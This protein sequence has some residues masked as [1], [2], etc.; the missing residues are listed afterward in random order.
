MFCLIR[1]IVRKALRVLGAVAVLSAIQTSCS[2]SSPAAASAAPVTVTPDSVAATIMEVLWGKRN[3]MDE[4]LAKERRWNEATEAALDAGRTPTRWVESQ[5]YKKSYERLDKLADSCSRILSSRVT[6]LAWVNGV[7]WL[8]WRDVEP[9]RMFN[10]LV[11]YGYRGRSNDGI[12]ASYADLSKDICDVAAQVAPVYYRAYPRVEYIE[13]VAH[14][15]RGAVLGRLG[16]TRRGAEIVGDSV[17]GFRR[18]AQQGLPGLGL[19]GA[20]GKPAFEYKPNRFF[21]H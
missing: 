19:D 5:S 16:V 11:H 10:I 9:K 2:T 21:L 8:S 4:L 20:V 1:A 17:A 6:G 7:A 3:L 14:N 15:T 13:V 18:A 12:R